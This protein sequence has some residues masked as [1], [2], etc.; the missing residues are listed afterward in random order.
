MMPIDLTSVVIIINIMKW[1]IS[2]AEG[3]TIRLMMVVTV[4]ACMK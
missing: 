2:I 1:G 4:V 3:I